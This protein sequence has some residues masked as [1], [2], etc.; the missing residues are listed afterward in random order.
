MKPKIGST[1]N[2]E[3]IRPNDVKTLLGEGELGCMLDWR[4]WNPKTN[5]ILEEHTQK[6]ESFVQQFLQ[7][8]MVEFIKPFIGVGNLLPQVRD[9]TNTLRYCQWS[10]MQN[11]SSINL[12]VFANAG[13]TNQGIVCGTGNTAPAITDYALQT[14]IA[15]GAGAGQ[16]QYG[17][18][19]Y[20]LP[21][22]D[23]VS[24]SQLT[25]T[26]S[27]TSNAGGI[28]VNE[29]GLYCY[30]KDTAGQDRNFMIIH[31]VIA[32]GIAV[33]AGQTL[34]INYRPQATI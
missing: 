14:P 16:L 22:T 25:I 24:T 5:E 7:L 30:S 26:R 3:I 33:P 13:T 18:T 27:F 8:L 32:G 15:N 17:G 21:G 10:S 19:S 6:S 20:A 23:G 2:P 28:T 1:I 9:I 31:D 29:I 12:S 34:T 4:V 11:Q